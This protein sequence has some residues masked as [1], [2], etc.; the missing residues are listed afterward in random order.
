MG[1]KRTYAMN[2]LLLPNSS[3][4]LVV[5]SRDLASDIFNEKRCRRQF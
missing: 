2:R 5:D 4:T 1:Y 3:N